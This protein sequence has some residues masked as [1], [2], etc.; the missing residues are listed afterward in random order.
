[1][2]R[3]IKRFYSN[4]KPCNATDSEQI[5]KAEKNQ[6]PFENKNNPDKHIP[7]IIA[8]NTESKKNTNTTTNTTTKKKSDT[9]T[10]ENHYEDE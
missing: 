6:H 10:K 3:I 8:K 1:M 7:K 2:K 9:K 5:V 4:W